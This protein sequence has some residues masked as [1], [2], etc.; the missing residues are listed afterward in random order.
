MQT[1][2]AAENYS[3]PTATT[4]SVSWTSII[5]D[6]SYGPSDAIATH[7]LFCKIQLGFTFL[8]PDKRPLNARRGAGT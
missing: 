6:G 4:Q 3:G 1:C 7:C 8:I 5:L 2:I